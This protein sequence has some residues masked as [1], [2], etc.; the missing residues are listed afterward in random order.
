MCGLVCWTELS[1]V[2]VVRRQGC[3][4]LESLDSLWKI[5]YQRYYAIWFPGIIGYH[6]LVDTGASFQVGLGICSVSR[7]DF[8]FDNRKS[9]KKVTEHDIPNSLCHEG[10][11]LMIWTMNQA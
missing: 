6:L 7:F 1:K 2:F 8:V 4:K 3:E 11:E 10:T 5:I 9:F